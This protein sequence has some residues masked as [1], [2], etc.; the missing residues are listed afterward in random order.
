MQK[1]IISITSVLSACALL[2]GCVTPLK[3]YQP[4]S[5]EEGA[6]KKVLV[7][8]E[9]AWNNNDIQGYLAV[10]HDSGNFMYGKERYIVS[11]QEFAERIPK[12]RAVKPR[13]KF[14]TPQI[15]ITGDKAVVNLVDYSIPGGWPWTVHLVRENENWYIMRNEYP[16][17]PW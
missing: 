3:E 8:S 1:K 7:S 5:P 11:K 12:I 6:I 16:A 4:K 14:G 15:T 10:L 9:N 2:L 13:F 17:P